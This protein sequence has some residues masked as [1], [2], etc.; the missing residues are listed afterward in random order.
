MSL[1]TEALTWR[2]ALILGALIPPFRYREI[3]LRRL[4]SGRLKLTEAEK[5]LALRAGDSE[6]Q[7]FF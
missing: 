1:N 3:V 5:M 2:E 6:V 7:K 4:K